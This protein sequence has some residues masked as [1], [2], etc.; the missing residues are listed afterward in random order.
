[1]NTLNW[2]INKWKAFVIIFLTFTTFKQAFVNP[3]FI[4]GSSFYLQ[5]CILHTQTF[6]QSEPKS[7]RISQPFSD[8]TWLPA[9]DIISAFQSKSTQSFCCFLNNQRY[10]TCIHYFIM[11]MWHLY[12]SVW[13]WKA[14]G[15]LWQ[16]S[17]Q[18]GSCWF[19]SWQLSLH[20]GQLYISH[21]FCQVKVTTHFTA[22]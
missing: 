3:L 22:Y 6:R 8:S 11:L 13:A 15:C 17:G 19:F 16:L 14:Q 9:D 21:L 1:M 18:S 2:F 4:C 20:W 5:I 7:T 12:I 10:V